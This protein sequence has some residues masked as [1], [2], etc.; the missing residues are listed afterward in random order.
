MNTTSEA[1]GKALPG[2]ASLTKL[3]RA[4]Q[5]ASGTGGATRKASFDGFGSALHEQGYYD[6][7]EVVHE[8]EEEAKRKENKKYFFLSII[9]YP[10]FF[11]T[12]LLFL[13]SFLILKIK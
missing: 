4:L 10:S 2:V 9:S 13:H 12:Y 3:R 11:F 1:R 7:G 5:R 6:D 8:E